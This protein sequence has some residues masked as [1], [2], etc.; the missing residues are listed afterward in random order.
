MAAAVADYH[1]KNVSSAKIK[2]QASD[3]TLELVKTP[4]I[5]G[6]ARG[7]FIKV[8]FAAESENMIANAR[9][10]LESK[11]LDII[12]AND[13]TEAAS[14]FAVDTNKVT[15]IDKQ[16]TIQELPLMTKREVADKILDRVGELIKKN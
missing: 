5:L 10:K 4:D 12:V 11:K 13:I 14:G 15:L 9:Q 3:L 8:G 16:G 1:P 2:K 7:S 6:E